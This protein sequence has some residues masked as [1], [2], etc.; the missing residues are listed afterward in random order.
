[1]NS[2]SVFLYSI[3]ILRPGYLKKNTA[4]IPAI[5]NCS[6]ITQSTLCPVGQGEYPDLNT[7]INAWI[8]AFARM[9]PRTIN[10][11]PAASVYHF[12]VTR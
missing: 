10:R 6:C 4:V 5:G 3:V 1:M 7:F 11:Y 12:K 8:P 2:F 9:T